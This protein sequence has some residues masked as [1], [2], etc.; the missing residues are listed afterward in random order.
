M[1]QPPT[2]NGAE[3]GL[4]DLFRRLA[5]HA[6]SLVRGEVALAKL[7]LRDAARALVRDSGK[8]AVAFALAWFGGLALT[9]AAAIGVGH[10]LGGRFGFGAL[11]VGALFLLVGAILAR[12]GMRAMSSGELRPEVTLSSLEESRAWAKDEIRELRQ[13]LRAPT[14]APASAPAGAQAIES[15]GGRNAPE[16]T[17][18]P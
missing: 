18:Q 12:S 5:D 10:L 4:T 8:L 9:A 2:A 14:S 16:R 13:E 15:P 7:E 3:P 6:S 1:R 17:L 11:I